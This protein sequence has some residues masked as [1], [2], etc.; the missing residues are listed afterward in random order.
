MLLLQI[1]GAAFAL[2]GIVLVIWTIGSPGPGGS[3]RALGFEINAPVSFLLIVLGA[4]MIVGSFFLPNRSGSSSVGTTTSASPPTSAILPPNIPESASTSEVPSITFDQ[5]EDPIVPESGFRVA[6]VSQG[7]KTS[8]KLW[9]VY[10]ATDRD[11]GDTYQPNDRSC[12]LDQAGRWDC[13]MAY[14]GGPEDDNMKFTLILLRVTDQAVAEFVAYNKS[15]PAALGYPGFQELPAGSE[16][17]GTLQ[18]QRES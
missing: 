9:L 10:I 2:V 15:D 12:T 6:G 14:V 18:V 7:L 16:Q 13:F 4:A 8:D 17:I 11:S 3:A 1:A 5:P